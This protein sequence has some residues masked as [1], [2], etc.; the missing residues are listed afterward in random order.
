MKK[1]LYFYF[2]KRNTTLTL[3]S[4]WTTGIDFDDK[5]KTSFHYSWL[6]VM[7]LRVIP[8]IPIG[9]AIWY[10]SKG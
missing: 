5:N 4:D 2:V 9:I 7:I 1:Y 6:E 10:F 3:G 8:F